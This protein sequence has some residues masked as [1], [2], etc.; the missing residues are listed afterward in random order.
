MCVCIGGR[1][2]VSA[3]FVRGRLWV[4]A[5]VMQVCCMVRGVD[6][7]G[8]DLDRSWLGVLVAT[9]TFAD[10]W[11]RTLVVAFSVPWCTQLEFTFGSAD[12]WKVVVAAVTCKSG[13][14]AAEPSRPLCWEARAVFCRSHTV[15][16][17]GAC[18]TLPSRCSATAEGPAS[19]HRGPNN[20]PI[21]CPDGTW[22][23]CH[24]A[25]QC[26]LRTA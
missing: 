14:W 18:S 20:G 11:P 22:P 1:Q 6:E 4:V 2:G 24:Q 3:R 10:Q 5:R 26:L 25:P 12:R 16:C 21:P 19:E 17:V 8:Q 13:R 15:G 9:L 7:E 23:P